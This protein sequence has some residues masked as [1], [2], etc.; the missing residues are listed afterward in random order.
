MLPINRVLV[1]GA[2]GFVGSSVVT[3]LA[4]AGI[5]LRALVRPTSRTAALEEAGAEIVTGRLDDPAALARAVAGTDVVIHMAARTHARSEAEYL[6]TNTDATRRLVRAVLDAA[7]RPSRLLFLSS[8]AAAGPSRTGQPVR[9]GDEPRPL[10]AYGRSKLAGERA[11]AEAADR[12][13]VVILRAPAVYGPHDRE[14]L[15]FF[16]FAAAGWIPLPAGG[17]RP[18]QLVHVRDLAQAILLAAARPAAS[19]TFHVA[20]PQVTDMADVARCIADALGV[21]ARVVPVPRP[22]VFAL[23]LVAEA[24]NG[25]LR[26]SS[27][28]NR[29]KIRELVAPGWLCETEG[30][31]RAFGFEA[32]IALPEGLRETAEWYRR[33]GWLRA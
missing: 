12:L 33:N 6:A 29:D 9:P 17:P 26:R 28:I 10:T 20:H 3:T 23:G 25:G 21:R 19:G 30:A 22:L 32:R 27:M 11:C 14:M 4:G 13:E 24:I 18:L 16:R 5:P 15:R 1:T 7:P 2:T 8:L 31:L